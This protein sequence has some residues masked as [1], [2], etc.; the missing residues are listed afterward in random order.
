LGEPPI[1]AD[2]A[3]LSSSLSD[4]TIKVDASADSRNLEAG[5]VLHQLEL[6]FSSQLLITRFLHQIHNPL[7]GISLHAELLDEELS[8]RNISISEITE[9][10][11][12][13]KMDI[14]RL[15]LLTG[16]FYS[17]VRMPELNLEVTDLNELCSHLARLL[18]GRFLSRNCPIKT[19]F[20]SEPLPAQVDP[21]QL[22][23][24]LLHLLD[25]AADSMDSGGEIVLATSKRGG[26]IE[27]SVSDG[28]RGIPETERNK[29]FQPFF[30]TKGR[31]TGLGLSCCRKIVLAH[32]GSVRFEAQ[33]GGGTVFTMSLPLFDQEE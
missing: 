2:D 1:L 24:A 9:L 19:I 21:D 14:D 10:L 23:I 25:N 6:P 32:G 18:E 7:S 29:I 15:S 4:P 33:P 3:C 17:Y 13:I 11:N 5:E 31:G 8:E 20:G 12:S 26:F 22:N 30:S 16:E 27:I 28:G